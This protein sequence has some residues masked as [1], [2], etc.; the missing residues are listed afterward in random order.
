MRSQDL[1]ILSQNLISLIQ[2]SLSD[3]DRFIH[4]RGAHGSRSVDSLEN[5]H[6]KQI[7]HS[8]DHKA[9]YREPE[10]QQD[11]VISEEAGDDTQKGSERLAE[12]YNQEKHDP[13]SE[14]TVIQI[15]AANASNSLTNKSR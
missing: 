10:N 8:I 9:H 15:Q 7:K 2:F 6:E 5:Q 11:L 14:K 3:C 12:D 4:N 13:V 1:L